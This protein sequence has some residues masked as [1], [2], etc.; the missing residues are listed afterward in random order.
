MPRTTS[1]GRTAAALLPLDWHFEEL[2]IARMQNDIALGSVEQ[3]LNLALCCANA[4]DHAP[5]T[6]QARARLGGNENAAAANQLLFDQQ[7]VGRGG[8]LTIRASRHSRS[9]ISH[10]AETKKPY[11]EQARQCEQVFAHGK[12]AER[13]QPLLRLFRISQKLGA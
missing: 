10:D 4:D 2:Y 8:Q 7:Q 12:A 3:D 11:V 5:L 6:G 1:A 9:F 13:L